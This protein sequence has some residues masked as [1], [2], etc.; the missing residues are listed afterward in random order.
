MSNRQRAALPTQIKAGE[1]VAW[2]AW[3]VTPCG[4]LMSLFMADLWTTRKPMRC[5]DYSLP[6]ASNS[7]GIHAC[8]RKSKA[9]FHARVARM[10]ASECYEQAHIVIGQ[11]ALWGK[12]IEHRWGYRAEFAQIKNLSPLYGNVDIAKLRQDYGVGK[13]PRLGLAWLV[14]RVYGV[15]AIIFFGSLG[16][17][18]AM[19]LRIFLL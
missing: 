15:M 14:A 13:A 3:R 10:G 18:I 19:L 11:V 17:G 12:T 8:K 5:R 16:W 7:S 2:R 6:G 4:S 1:V 9:A